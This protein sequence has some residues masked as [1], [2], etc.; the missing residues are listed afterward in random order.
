MNTAKKIRNLIAFLT[1][2][3]VG[4]DEDYLVDAS[5]Y[6]PLFPLIGATVGFAVGVSAWILSAL[7]SGLILGGVTLGLLLMV[8]GLHHTDGLLDFGDGIMCCGAPEKKIEAMRDHTVGVGG[9]ILGLLTM[10]ITIFCISDLRGENLIR[11]LV[12]SETSAKQAM[13]VGAAIGRSAGEGMNRFFID[14]MHGKWRVPRVAATLLTSSGI[15]VALMG[16]QG[17][18]VVSIS[19]LASLFIVWVS[20]RHFRGLTGDVMG[21]MNDLVRMA[22]LVTISAVI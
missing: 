20:N 9:V 8:S 3:P 7:L 4:M 12:V 14:S 6:M 22:S 10:L 18:L 15:S 2:I 21:A 19:L 16:G 11:G 13:V 17:L 1:V 5:D